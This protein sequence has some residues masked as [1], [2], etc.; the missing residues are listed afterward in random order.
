MQA[1]PPL[2]KTMLKDLKQNDYSNEDRM[3]FD[4][5]VII[6]IESKIKINYI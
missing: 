5:L 3:E 2:G 6:F 4:N 1:C